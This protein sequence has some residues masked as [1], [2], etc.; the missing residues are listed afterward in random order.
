[1]AAALR[2]SVIMLESF[3]VMVMLGG[4]GT[5]CC[6]F[7]WGRGTAYDSEIWMNVCLSHIQRL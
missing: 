2:E 3:M 7:V 6:E 4:D 5:C 1:M